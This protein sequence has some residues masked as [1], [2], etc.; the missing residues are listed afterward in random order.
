[1][2]VWRVKDPL[3]P[4]GMNLFLLLLASQLCQSCLGEL[5]KVNEGGHVVT[6]SYI[7]TLKPTMFGLPLSNCHFAYGGRFSHVLKSEKH[8]V[9]DFFQLSIFSHQL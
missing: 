8:I 4:M 7:S 5:K 3:N 2:E 9:T 1:M 6:S